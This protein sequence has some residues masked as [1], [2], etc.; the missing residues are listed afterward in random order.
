MKNITTYNQ[1][2]YTGNYSDKQIYAGNY[3]QQKYNE[4]QIFLVERALKGLNIYTPE[5]IKSMHWDKKK[6]INL[7][8]NR[9]KMI[10]N[11]WKQ[12]LIIDKTNEFL[13]KLLPKAMITKDFIDNTK[14]DDNYNANIPLKTF[15]I[16]KQNIIDK[17]ME[18]KIL[19][20]NYYTLTN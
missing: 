4:Y 9:C 5:E 18:E 3:Q 17:L 19:P 11:R 20:K 16:S 8:H 2:E 7:V 6:R 13:T 14:L 15:G 1:V 12:Q 10:M